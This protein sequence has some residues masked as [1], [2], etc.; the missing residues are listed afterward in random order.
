[1]KPVTIVH[2]RTL[3]R[4][5]QYSA[6]NFFDIIFFNFVRR[7]CRVVRRKVSY[8]STLRL[9]GCKNTHGKN[10]WVERPEFQVHSRFSRILDN[11]EIVQA[12]RNFTCFSLGKYCRLDCGGGSA[13]LNIVVCTYSSR[14]LFTSS[15]VMFT[16]DHTNFEI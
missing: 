11:P 10:S 16:S 5:H 8:G 2:D 7:S 1:M 4:S 14:R 6:I 15:I 9:D 13:F 12:E 3:A